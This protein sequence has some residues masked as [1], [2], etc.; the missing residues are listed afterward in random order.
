M[1]IPRLA[2]VATLLS[3]V[4]LGVGCARYRIEV[5]SLAPPRS[6]LAFDDPIYVGG[7]LLSTTPRA[8]HVTTSSSRV[9]T[10]RSS[11]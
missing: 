4:L 9:P 1:V 6:V 11:A 10:L 2:R 8:G 3:L 7:T 5:F